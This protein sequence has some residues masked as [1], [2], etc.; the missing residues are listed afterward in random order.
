MNTLLDRK[1]T[2]RKMTYENLKKIYKMQAKAAGISLEY[3][4]NKITSQWSLYHKR[5]LTNL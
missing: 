3:T 4:K 1:D 5:S 2:L